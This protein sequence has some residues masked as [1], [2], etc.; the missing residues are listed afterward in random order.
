M[1]VRIDWQRKHWRINERKHNKMGKSNKNSKNSKNRK[2]AE[3]TG[4]KEK[5]VTR[6]DRKMEF[7]RQQEEKEKRDA[8]RWKI[9]TLLAGICV[10][11][12]IAGITIRSAVKKQAALKDTYITVGNHELTKLEYDY[13][14]NITVNNYI[15]TYYSYLSYMGLDV[16]KDFA[17][18]TYSGDITW[19]DNFDQMTVNSIVEIKAMADDAKAQEFEYDV[20]EDYTSYV[21]GLKS[22]ASESGLSAAKYYAASF[23]NYATQSNVEPFIKEM[24]CVT[25]YHNHLSEQM[26]PSEEEIT[27]YYEENKNIYDKVNYHIFQF[28]ADLEEDVEEDAVTAAMSELTIQADEMVTRLEAGEDFETLCEEYAEEEQKENYSDADTEYS[29]HENTSYYSISSQYADWLYEETREAGELTKIEDT[30]N[31]IIYVVRFDERIYDESC[32]ETISDRLTDKNVT[33][34]LDGLTENYEVTDVK[35]ELN[36]LA[37]QEATTADETTTEETT[38]GKTE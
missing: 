23:G 27:S 29:F 12:I 34:Y 35:G 22:G 17:E 15:N 3:D 8:K 1:N 33:E 7:R 14:Y 19:K 4:K 31:H 5:V 28:Y 32:R 10:I 36:Y 6:Y 13:Y 30:E 20:T 37:N 9:G 38:I 24:L 18:Q 2:P 11:C 26:A 16:T 21:E 25:A